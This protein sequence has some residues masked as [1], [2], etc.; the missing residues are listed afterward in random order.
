[1]AKGGE[2]SSHSL[3]SHSLLL[4]GLAGLCAHVM[5]LCDTCAVVEKENSSEIASHEPSKWTVLVEKT[6]V[7][8]GNAL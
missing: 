2:V 4:L 1:M 6:T 7:Q 5:R 8:Q 3:R